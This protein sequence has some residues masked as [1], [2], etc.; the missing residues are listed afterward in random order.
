MKIKTT[1]SGESIIQ[2]ED[3]WWSYAVYDASGQKKSTGY[4]VGSV[5]PESILGQS[6]NIPY[7]ML[8]RRANQKR[9]EANYRRLQRMPSPMRLSANTFADQKNK[10]ALVILAQ[11]KGDDEK[12]KDADAKGKFTAMLTQNGYSYNGATGCAKEY[13][14]QQFNGKH[15]FSFDVTD[16]VTVSQRRSYYGANDKNGND[17]NPHEM[18]MEAC[19]LADEKIDFK[20]Y[21]QDGDGEVDNVFVFFAG[22]DEAS[23]AE[24][25]HIW[26]HAW[27]IMDGAGEDLFL[28]GVRINR[29]A[30][31]AELEGNTY[32]KSYMT[33]IGTFCHEYSHTLGLP[34]FYDTDY[35]EGGFAA[36]LWLCTSLMDGGNYNNNGNKAFMQNI[37]SKDGG[38]NHMIFARE[39][40][41]RLPIKKLFALSVPQMLVGKD[42]AKPYIDKIVQKGNERL[43][44]ETRHEIKRRLEKIGEK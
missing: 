6:R 27:F 17:K 19:K 7:D 29:Y 33:A 11:F 1:E 14:D 16:V 25:D 8:V 39:G 30:C 24:E 3:G 34:D 12:F 35:P 5:S 40:K 42:G 26:S 23:G 43:L 22:L 4:H 9:R 28:D 37:K 32:D 41:A 38:D 44:K 18:V 2:D 10:A 36:A 13:F 21:D 15:D 20:K 31:A